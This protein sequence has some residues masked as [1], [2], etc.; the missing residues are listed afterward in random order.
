ME[1][2]E[3]RYRTEGGREEGCQV[4]KEEKKGRKEGF[5][6]KSAPVGR[7][8]GREGGRKRGKRRKKQIHTWPWEVRKVTIVWISRDK[9]YLEGRKERKEGRK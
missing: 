4:M 1:G 8:E 6:T 7:K 5:P 2:E 3:E 9:V